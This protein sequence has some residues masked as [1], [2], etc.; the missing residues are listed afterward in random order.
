MNYSLVTIVPAAYREAV[1]AAAEANGYGPNNV[2]CPLTTGEGITHYGSR[3]W[4]N[5]NFRDTYEAMFPAQL[6]AV[7]IIDWRPDSERDDHFDAVLAENNL[8][9]VSDELPE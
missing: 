7:C 6:L 3:A 4:A 9:R 8:Q 2:A 1:R 5:Q